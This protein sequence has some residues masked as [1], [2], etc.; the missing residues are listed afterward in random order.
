MFSAALRLIMTLKNFPALQ[1][2]ELHLGFSVFTFSSCPCVSFVIDYILAL[3]DKKLF[4]SLL[5]YVKNYIVKLTLGFFYIC[6]LNRP[7]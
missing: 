5:C 7:Q 1:T 6:L 3:R 2:T 4:Y